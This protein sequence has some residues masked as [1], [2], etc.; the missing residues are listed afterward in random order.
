M[1]CRTVITDQWKDPHGLLKHPHTEICGSTAE[2]Q[3]PCY[4]RRLTTTECVK[5]EEMGRKCCPPLPKLIRAWK[6][7]SVRHCEVHLLV[8]GGLL[9]HMCS[10]TCPCD[11]TD[12]RDDVCRCVCVCMCAFLCVSLLPGLINFYGLQTERGGNGRA[13]MLT[14]VQIHFTEDTKYTHTHTISSLALFRLSWSWLIVPRN[15]I[16]LISKKTNSWLFC[17]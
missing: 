16:G 17:W 3:E 10:F 12:K 6:D 14:T 2:V 5:F 8:G 15:E 11:H 7:K 4:V 1:S 9:V 13:N